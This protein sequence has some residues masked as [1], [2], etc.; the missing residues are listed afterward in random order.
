MLYDIGLSPGHCF[1]LTHSLAGNSN[2]SQVPAT[3]VECPEVGDSTGPSLALPQ[4][5]QA[6]QEAISRWKAS[7]FLFLS[8]KITNENVFKRTIRHT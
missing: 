5:A 1:L 8:N 4:L 7:L 2:G 3:H 6:V